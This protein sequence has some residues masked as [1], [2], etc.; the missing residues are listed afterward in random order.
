MA[1]DYVFL[2]LIGK[3]MFGSVWTAQDKLTNQLVAIKVIPKKNLKTRR[4]VMR[5]LGDYEIPKYLGCTHKNIVCVR[6]IFEN[7]DEG[8]IYIVSEYISNSVPLDEYEPD[9][10]SPVGRLELL[11]IFQQLADGLDYIHS[12]NIAHRDIKLKNILLKGDIPFYIDYDLACSFGPILRQ[13]ECKYNSLVGTPNYMAPEI[14]MRTVHDYTASDIYAL[15]I[16]FYYLITEELPYK[17]DTIEKTYSAIL[18]AELPSFQ[19]PYP[20]LD[21]L[22]VTMLSPDPTVRPNAAKV[23]GILNAI[24]KTI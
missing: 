8:N 4:S 23:R 18:R 17:R 5:A 12:K 22:I 14:V 2:D 7:E 6:D 21:N 24:I 11:N 16:V 20:E 9:L 19:S 13:F 1:Q 10:Q 15:G 3:G